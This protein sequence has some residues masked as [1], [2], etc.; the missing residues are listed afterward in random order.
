M[1]YQRERQY[2][3]GNSTSAYKRSNTTRVRK[4][5]AKPKAIKYD[6]SSK[7]DRSGPKA[8]QA[9]GY[10][11]PGDTSPLLPKLKAAQRNPKEWAPIPATADALK[12]RANKNFGRPGPISVIE[13]SDDESDMKAITEVCITYGVLSV[14]TNNVLGIL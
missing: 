1:Q 12:R 13:L 14:L 9:R 2:H 3:G 7:D 6:Q 11:N 5:R 10:H 8:K 4:T